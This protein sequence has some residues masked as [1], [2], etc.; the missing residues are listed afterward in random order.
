M[1][2]ARLAYPIAVGLAE[3]GWLTVLYLLVDA[4]ARVPP[5]LGL[6]AF[7]LVA[8]GTCLLADRID[9]LAPTRVMVIAGLIV[10][11]GLLGLIAAAVLTV[12]SGTGSDIG[13]TGD[14]GAVLLGLAALRGFIRAGA[15]RDPDEAARPFLLGLLGLSAMWIAGGVLVEPMRSAFRAAAIVPTLGFIVGAVASTGLARSAIAAAGADFDPRSNRA[16]SVALVG[17]AVALGVA[18]LPL[19]TAAERLMAAVI[20]WPVSLPLLIFLAIVA[21]LLIPS[22]GG[23]LRRAGT[24]TLGPLIA[25]GVLALAAIVLPPP[26]KVPGAEEA[27]G[28]GVNSA[29][30][31]T[32]VFD[33]ALAV[34]AIVVVAAVL[35]YLARAWR[36]NAD[37]NDRLRGGDLR[38]RLRDTSDTDP[39]GGW[40]IGRRLRALARRG[41]PT[42]AVTAYLAVLRSLEA[43]EGLE[44]GPDETPAAHARRLHDIG[45]GSLELDLLAADFE[46][47]R[48]GGRAISRAE[49][50]RAIGR[51]ERLRSR[52]ADRPQEG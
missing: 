5:T 47:A 13:P 33:V 32:P 3:G 23:M 41:R 46:L 19:G 6:A 35:L 37:G 20:A 34:L 36:M 50:R 43:H 18:A 31:T 25:L 42:D 44:R 29:E 22:R 39:D 17:L 8:A 12:V 1:S 14:P 7:A 4:V 48:W 16:W 2:P 28:S 9:R 10:G 21:R 38:G 40:G 51:W 45:A 11:G 15:L 52:F 49:D 30:P 26:A 24:Y 27:S